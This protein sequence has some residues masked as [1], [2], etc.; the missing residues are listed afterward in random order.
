M[1]FIKN[2][3]VEQNFDKTLN[4]LS[5]IFYKYVPFSEFLP[6][7]ERSYELARYYK[8]DKVLLNLKLLTVHDEETREYIANVWFP[9]IKKEG[10]NHVAF[11]L[12]D[13][14]VGKMS[15][16]DAH[17]NSQNINGLIIANFSD[18]SEARAWLSNQ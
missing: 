14:T 16:Q 11:I 9:T 15:A 4:V 10:V 8:A 12:P 13:S 6:I 7:F 3:Y 17:K 1:E 18:E 5:A 2:Q